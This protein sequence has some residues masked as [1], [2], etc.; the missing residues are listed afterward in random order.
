MAVTTYERLMKKPELQKQLSA[1]AGVLKANSVIVNPDKLVAI[2]R[3]L[4]LFRG[5][6]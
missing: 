4:D 1:F 3:A 2:R 5:V 6:A